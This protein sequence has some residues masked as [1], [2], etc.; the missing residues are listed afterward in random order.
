M[1]FQVEQDIVDSLFGAVLAP[2]TLVS[3]Y[4]VRNLLIQGSLDE[5]LSDLD[6]AWLET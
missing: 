5:A 1:N 4:W 3:D 2:E 6:F